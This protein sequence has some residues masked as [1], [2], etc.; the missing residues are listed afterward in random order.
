MIDRLNSQ[1]KKQI[2]GTNF[3]TVEF[4]LDRYQQ[5]F[6]NYFTLEDDD[7]VS[8]S[9]AMVSFVRLC[10]L[11]DKQSKIVAEYES[12]FKELVVNIQGFMKIQSQE[13]QDYYKELLKVKLDDIKE[14]SNYAAHFRQVFA[15]LSQDFKLTAFDIQ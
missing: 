13:F 1:D 10:K 15:V 3:D 5:N 14:A 12:L 2:F 7:V 9:E 6:S 4:V 8:S 11:T